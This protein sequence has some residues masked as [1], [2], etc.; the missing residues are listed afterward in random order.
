MATSANPTP[1]QLQV[2]LNGPALPPPPGVIP[3]LDHPPN[4]QGTGIAVQIVCLVLS[5]IALCMRLYTKTRIIRQLAVYVGYFVPSWLASDVAGGVH[6]WDLRL[7]YLGSF[8]YYVHVGSVMYGIC[9]WFIKFSILLQYLQI[10]VPIKKASAMYLTCHALIWIN[11]VFYLVSTFVEIF[12]CSPVRKAWDPLVTR[13]RCI[14]ILALNVAAS[15]L[16]SVSDIAI[17]IVPQVGIWRLQMSQQKKMQISAI[18]LIG[19]FAC[20]ASIVRLGYAIKLYTHHDITYYS[21]L[22]GL[23]THPEMASGILVACLP[24]SAKFFQKLQQTHFFSQ[25][26]LSLQSLLRFT[27][28]GSKRSTKG[29][30]TSQ[31]LSPQRASWPKSYEMLSDGQRFNGGKSMGDKGESVDESFQGHRPQQARPHIIRTVDVDA[32]SESRRESDG[33]CENGP[34]GVWQGSSS[35]NVSV[36][37]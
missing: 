7:K 16:N 32:R 23:W 12:A 21:W 9:I 29:H 2:L 11:F 10:F 6:Q 24:V 19:I 13:G 14:N 8:L 27:S 25:I 26:G 1:E 20:V 37:V 17:L 33:D 35:Y 30:S 3:Q 5:T 4:L 18:F 22:T 34:Q 15:T 36:V 31:Q 28:S